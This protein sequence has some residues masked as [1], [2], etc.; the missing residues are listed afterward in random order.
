MKKALK[1]KLNLMNIFTLQLL[2]LNQVKKNILFHG[3][4]WSEQLTA[5]EETDI[6]Y[7]KA[8]NFVK[9]FSE[10]NNLGFINAGITSYSPTLMK[11]QLEI[12]EKD[13]DIT[14]NIVIAYIDQT[15]IGDEN[16]RYKNNRIF[17]NNEVIA[18]KVES[19]SGKPF[20]LFKNIR[21]IRNFSERKNL[22][23]KRPLIY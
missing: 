18:V 1:K 8:R 23:L 12:L 16:C 11:L 17:K 2:A 22:K 19:Y 15:D 9:D 10:I 6:R 7:L 20:R 4:S 5:L 14:P 13:F 21:G 3:D